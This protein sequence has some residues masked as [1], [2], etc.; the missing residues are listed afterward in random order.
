MNNSILI[1]QAAFFMSCFYL[2]DIL[3]DIR[4]NKLAYELDEKKLILKFFV[5][6]NSEYE[7][8][9]CKM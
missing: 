9:K 5:D 3:I 2:K 4:S 8:C 1:T 7:K 6:N